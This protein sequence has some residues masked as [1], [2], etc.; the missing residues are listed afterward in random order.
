MLT[1]TIKTQIRPFTFDDA[2]AVVT[3]FNAHEQQLYGCDDVDLDEMMNDWTSPG[4][5]V[6][7]VIRVVENDQGEIVGYIDVWDNSSPHVVKYVWGLLHPDTWDD[8]IYREMLCW[9]EKCARDRIN[10]SPPETR[11]IMRQG[12]SDKDIQRNKAMESYGY[13]LVRHFYRMEIDLDHAPHPPVIPKGLTITPIDMDTELQDAILATDEAFKDHW[14]HVE[15]PLEELMEQWEHFI[16]NDHD[17]DP[18]LWYLAKDGDVIAGACRCAGKTIEDPQLG[19]VNNLSVQKPWRRK[20]LGTALLLTAFNEYYR[21]GKT[22]VGLGVDA[23]SL[24]NATQ[25]YEKA[26]MHVSRQY[27]T[28]EMELRPGKDLTTTNKPVV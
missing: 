21:R 3:L 9:A 17:F 20:G 1:T 16:A 11:V 14:G 18:S 24:T 12:T 28:Y 2:Q 25:L 10:L 5:N 8:E 15:Q 27:N 6:E 19:W 7:E 23:A 26:G 4:I 22:R 13:K